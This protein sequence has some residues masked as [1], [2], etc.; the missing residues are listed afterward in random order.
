MFRENDP[1]VNTE[2]VGLFYLSDSGSQE[3]DIFCQEARRAIGQIDREE[4][5]AT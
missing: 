3:I 5:A 1:G 2:G 4:E